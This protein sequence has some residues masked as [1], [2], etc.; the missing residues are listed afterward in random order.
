MKK[1]LGLLLS[2][3]VVGVLV[4]LAFFWRRPE[5]KPQPEQTT[6]TPLSYQLIDLSRVKSFLLENDYGSI[7]FSK[8]EYGIWGIVEPV[9]S[10]TDPLFFGGMIDVLS[11]TQKGRVVATAEEES[12]DKYGLE[13]PYARFTFELDSGEKKHLRIG[14]PNPTMSYL[15]AWYEESPEI[16][17][18]HPR[19]RMFLN[20]PLTWYRFRRL[21]GIN[22]SQVSELKITVF[23]PE[24]RKKLAVPKVR[25][26][27]CE[28]TENKIKWYLLEPVKEEAESGAVSNF[29]GWLEKVSIAEEVQDIS[30]EQEKEWGL[31]S[32]RAEIEILYPD[33]VQKVLIGAEKNNL[34][35]LYQPEQHK[36]L[37]YPL[38]Q[39]YQLLGTEFRQRTLFPWEERE[40]VDEVEIIF[41]RRNY[42]YRLVKINDKEWEVKDQPEKKFHKKRTRWVFRALYRTK[43]DGYINQRPIDFKKYGL[44]IPKIKIKYYKKGEILREFWI[45][46]WDAKKYKCYVYDPNKDLL[47]WY[48]ENIGEWFPPDE[49]YF[50]IKEGGNESE[51]EQ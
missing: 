47:V 23:D 6:S 30:P 35:Y 17:L 10:M 29:L 20:H 39:I 18:I 34:I 41:P 36:I 25:H 51:S 46:D 37:G 2:L 14:R 16:F 50:L 42:Q 43:I 45:G 40:Q 7:K 24:L 19:I 8:N 1:W 32:P 26:L 12:L 11:Q 3:I 38:E 22:S 5:S 48:S 31:A 28:V 27:L 4:W 33:R 13:N 21:I 49:K 44:Q 15:Y 9:K